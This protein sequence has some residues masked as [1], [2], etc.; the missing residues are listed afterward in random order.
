MSISDDIFDQKIKIFT[1][2]FFLHFMHFLTRG[3]VWIHCRTSI[4]TFEKFSNRVEYKT[5]KP[6]ELMPSSASKH[7]HGALYKHVK[8]KT[9][10]PRE[11]K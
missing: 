8:P 4:D 2:R 10:N 5:T 11:P 9:T 3:L 7:V 1:E 6:H